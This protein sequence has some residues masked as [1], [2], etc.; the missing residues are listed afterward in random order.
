[1]RVLTAG[2]WAAHGVSRP[3]LRSLQHSGDLVQLRHGVYATRN[4]VQWAGADQVRRHVLYLLAA[5]ATAGADT[6]ASYQSAA[7]LH[8][9]DLLRPPWS[10]RPPRTVH[11]PQADQVTLTVPPSCRWERPKTSSVVFHSANVPKDQ[12]TTRYGIPLTTPARTVA[13]LARTLPFTDAVVAADCALHA[14]KLTRKQLT[15]VLDDCPRWP[16]I[17][18]ARRVLEFADERAESP[19]ES[20]A[21]VVFDQFGLDPPDL[22][23]AVRLPQAA[24]RVDFYWPGR[25]TGPGLVAE[26][27]GLLKYN[28]RADLIRQLERDRLLRDAGYRVVH[29]TWEELFAR[30]GEVVDRIRRAA[31]TPTSY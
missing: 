3:L 15:E 9:I 20:A 4:A 23:A 17:R 19:L 6:V 29:F 1:M 16:G 2:Q 14:E 28:D 18:Q 11:P 24:F 13:D 30:P 25:E 31:A 10:A 12:R 22:Q 8:R 21:R 7:V 5:R 27:D 26:A